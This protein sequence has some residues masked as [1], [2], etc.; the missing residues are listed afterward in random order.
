M[1]IGGHYRVLQSLRCRVLQKLLLASK[2]PCRKSFQINMSV[3]TTC[4]GLSRMWWGI[5]G[6]LGFDG[7]CSWHVG[8]FSTVFSMHFDI[9]GLNI[10]SRGL[11]SFP[12]PCDQHDDLLPFEEDSIYSGQFVSVS[13]EFPLTLRTLISLRWG[14]R[15]RFLHGRLQWFIV[16]FNMDVSPHMHISGSDWTR[17]GWHTSPYQS[18][19]SLLHFLWGTW[20]RS[21]WVFHL[22]AEWHLIHIWM[23]WIASYAL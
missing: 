14:C 10:M 3:A 1:H 2:N 18:E 4:H 15:K 19:R 20:T 13:T 12:S 9:P 6:S 23:H 17:T 7:Q 11:C 21:W 22:L 8:Q 5:R 16:R